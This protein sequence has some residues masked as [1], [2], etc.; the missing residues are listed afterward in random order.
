MSSSL[1]SPQISYLSNLGL[2]QSS[3][4]SWECIVDISKLPIRLTKRKCHEVISSSG[5]QAFLLQHEGLQ[6]II[7]SLPTVFIYLK[8][9]CVH[10]FLSALDC[11]S[12]HPQD[13]S[14][15]PVL[16]RLPFFCF[17]ALLALPVGTTCHKELRN[18]LRKI[19]CSHQHHPQTRLTS[20][21]FQV[22]MINKCSPTACELRCCAF[23]VVPW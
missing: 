16:W 17:I 6:W 23:Q 5:P 22:F 15:S 9:E 12:K 18:I 3:L 8:N 10:L 21:N 13:G 14:L 1:I 2:T 7:N 4:L 11:K 19:H 20:P